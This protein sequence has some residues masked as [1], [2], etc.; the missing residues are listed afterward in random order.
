MPTPKLFELTYTKVQ[1]FRSCPKKYWF[2]YLSG[3]PTPPDVI[4]PAGLI[5]NGVH[6]AMKVLGETGDQ[7]AGASE[8][9]AYLR[10]PDHLI[11]GPGTLWYDS[12]FEIYGNGVTAHTSIGSARQQVERKTHAPDPERG[13]TIW[14]KIDRIDQL[15]D[16]SWQIIDWKTGKR[17][18][19]EET[20]EQLDLAHVALRRVERRIPADSD[21]DAIAWNLRSGRRRVRRLSPSHAAGTM[22]RYFLMFQKMAAAQEADGP[23]EALPGPI[24]SFCEWRPKCPEGGALPAPL[25]GLLD[26]EP[27][28]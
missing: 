20:D 24:C 25:A 28:E 9:D 26:E 10:M 12:A 17:D 23:W 21:V 15:D 18:S 3:E 7:E 8:L 5:G 19:D 4:T 6:R 1:A 14:S 13:F 2:K 27:E 16:G 11:C 22:R